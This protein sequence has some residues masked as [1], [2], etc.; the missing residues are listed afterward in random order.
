MFEKLKS[1]FKDFTKS[2][3]DVVQNKQ[4]SE[5][6][7][8]K[9]LDD[10]LI[11]LVESDVAYDVAEQIISELRTKLVG[12]KV[13][14]GTDI[15]NYIREMLKEEIISLM[16]GPT[17]SI[18]DEAKSKCKSGSP[19]VIAFFGINGVGKTTTIAKVAH[20]LKSAGITP[21]I[22]AAD[23]FRAGAQEQLKY[24]AE[25]L[26]VP[27]IGGSYGSDPA[28]VAYNAITFAKSRGLCAVLID[29]AGRMHI[30]ANLMNELKKIV[31]VAS[32]DLKILVVDALTGNDAVE[33]AKQFDAA[34]GI[35]AI[36]VT[37]IDADPKGGTT[38]SVAAVT[39]KPIIM[40]GT[41]QNYEDLVGFKPE[42]L[43]D[44]MIS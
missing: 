30:D 14:R 21:V 43:A 12:S 25:R 31:K 41:G 19:L 33:Q 9:P 22:A 44:S 6:D 2:L 34:I 11:S 28:S 39:R 4:L 5:K 38:L 29:T 1:A 26:N 40:L 23:T 37:K 7:V 16:K 32:P 8:E 15:G 18:V 3:K 17:I 24:H 42:Q 27:F 35:D 10:L 36:I 20:M 13:P